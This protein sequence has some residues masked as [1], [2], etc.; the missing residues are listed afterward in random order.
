MKNKKYKIVFEFLICVNY[1]I[2][3]L[4]KIKINRPNMALFSKFKLLFA[5]K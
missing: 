3:S 2:I 5:L 4:S 1:A